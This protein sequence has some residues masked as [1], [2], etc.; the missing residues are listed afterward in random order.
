M[1]RTSQLRKLWQSTL[2]RY[3]GWRAGDSRLFRFHRCH[4]STTR[5]CWSWHWRD[6]RSRTGNSPAA[7]CSL[8]LGKSGSWE[9]VER[10]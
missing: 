5:S 9:N 6:W 2:L 10:R 7:T 8:G 3:T 4:T 1:D